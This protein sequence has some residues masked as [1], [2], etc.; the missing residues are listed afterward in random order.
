MLFY[1]FGEKKLTEK[2]KLK[3]LFLAKTI[4]NYAKWVLDSE[5][6]CFSWVVAFW[7]TFDIQI[8]TTLAIFWE[9]CETTL[10]GKPIEI[11]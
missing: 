7:A 4:K 1:Y 2:M 9:K 5:R 6:I 10:F 11:S 8:D 3:T